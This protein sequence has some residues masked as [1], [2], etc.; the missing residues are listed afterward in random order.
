MHGRYEPATGHR[1]NP[2]KLLIDPYAKRFDG[3]GTWDDALF[4]YRIGAATDEADDR[5]SAAFV[6][7]S[8]LVNQAFVWGNDR[9]LR[10]PLDRTLIY[11][12]HV[13]GFTQLHPEVPDELRG[14]YAA[15]LGAAVDYLTNLGITA[16]EP[17]RSTSTSTSGTCSSAA[18]STTGA[19]TRSASSRPTCATAPPAS[20]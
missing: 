9:Q 17:C 1:F 14:T 20:R 13:K 8:V 2:A 4:G 16:V 15:R 18:S 3:T 5:D 6:P 11:E 7:K 10:T 19:T 12:V